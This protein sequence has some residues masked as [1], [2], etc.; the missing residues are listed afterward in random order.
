MMRP[1]NLI[2]SAIVR[3]PLHRL[4]SGTVILL[5]FRGRRSGQLY[6]IPV[7]YARSNGELILFA[8]GA[9]RK[10]WWRN[11]RTHPEVDVLVQGVWRRATGRVM[12]GDE[13]LARRYAD[14][15][16]SARRQIAREDPPVFVVLSLAESSP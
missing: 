13:A 12:A 3:S 15:F 7:Q 14:R 5:R 8:M 4:L 16:R 11:L 9:A 10:Q 1:D 2:I 6:T